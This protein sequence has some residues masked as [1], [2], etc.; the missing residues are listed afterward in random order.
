MFSNTLACHGRNMSVITVADPALND[1][2]YG[3]FIILKNTKA[4]IDDTL[5]GLE[6]DE[7]KDTVLM[8]D[9]VVLNGEVIVAANTWKETD[10]SELTKKAKELNEKYESYRP[11]VPLVGGFAFTTGHNILAILIGLAVLYAGII[12]SHYALDMPPFTRVFYFIYGAALFPFTHMVSVYNPPLWRA[13]LIPLQEGAKGLFAFLPPSPEDE[14]SSLFRYISV[15][16]L[17]GIGTFYY[18]LYGRIPV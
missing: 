11:R 18:S 6:K 4:D 14:P 15:A 17:L 9:L 12:A 3:P 13:T 8:N 16:M 2:K 7:S 1:V 5:K 10:I